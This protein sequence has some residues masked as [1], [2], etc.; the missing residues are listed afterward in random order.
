M[1]LL[2]SRVSNAV[3]AVLALGY[4]TFLIIGQSSAGGRYG[5]N[6]FPPGSPLWWLF[7]G[8]LAGAG[9]MCGYRA[10]RPAQPMD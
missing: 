4:A 2:P 3:S 9:L 6:L 7:V 5:G 10:L 8:V 1:N